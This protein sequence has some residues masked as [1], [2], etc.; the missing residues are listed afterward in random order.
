MLPASELG[1][2]LTGLQVVSCTLALIPISLSPSIAGLA[3][4]AYFWGAL[5]LGGLFLARGMCFALRRTDRDARLLLRA[6][7]IYLPI[8]LALLLLDLTKA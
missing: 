8:L 7:L 3:G 6:S 5:S 4:A 2:A 1:R